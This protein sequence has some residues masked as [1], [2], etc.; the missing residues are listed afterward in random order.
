LL[1]AF[2]QSRE[3]PDTTIEELLEQL[4]RPV[5]YVYSSNPIVL[6]EQESWMKR[7][8]SQ[9]GQI[10]QGNEQVLAVYGHLANGEKA[11]SARADLLVGEYEGVFSPAGIP[12][13]TS[14]SKLEMYARC[15]MQFFYHE[16]L[17]MRPK[18]VAAFDRTKWLSH[19]QKGTLLHAIFHRYTAQTKEQDGVHDLARL[20][21]ITEE[22]LARLRLEVPAPST[23]IMQK[24]CDEIRRDVE[25]FWAGEKKRDTVPKYLELAVHQPEDIFQVELSDELVLPLRAYVDRVDEVEPGKYRIVDYKTGAPRKFKEQEYFSRGKQLQHAIYAIAVEQWL[26]KTGDVPSAEV[27]ESSYYFPTEK[28][29][30]QEIVRKQNRREE[31]AALVSRLTESIQRGIFP[32][33]Q[34]ATI[35]TSCQYEAACGKQAKAMKKKREAAMNHE[36]LSPFLEV[37]DY[38]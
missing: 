31:T 7:L 4:G 13:A 18:E 9:S 37:E 15:P 28:G 14:V 21:K 19:T 35:C 16:V 23:P 11:A 36:R 8:I 6:D 33:T 30:G 26:R 34:E 1:D 5:G 38:A 32:P 2:R 29:Q 20:E 24:E 17:R 12:D 3:L 27:V 22:E 10:Y 25:V